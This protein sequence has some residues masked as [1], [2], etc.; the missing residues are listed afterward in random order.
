MSKTRVSKVRN[1]I[2]A[3]LGVELSYHKIADMC[4][5]LNIAFKPH[6]EMGIHY[7]SVIAESD[8]SRLINSFRHQLSGKSGPKSSA[9]APSKPAPRLSAA[10]QQT[11]ARPSKSPESH[12]RTTSPRPPQREPERSAAPQ[13]AAAGG[14]RPE[15][16]QR[17]DYQAR[18]GQRPQQEQRYTGGGQGRS[19]SQRPAGGGPS[20]RS[21]ASA[22]P[23]GS[24]P[25]S[26][27]GQRDFRPSSGPSDQRR[28]AGPSGGPGRSGGHHQRPAF[29]PGSPRKGKRSKYKQEQRKQHQQQQRENQVPLPPEERIIE[30]HHN[31]TVGELAAKMSV[32]AAEVIKALFMKGMMTTVNHVLELETA[33]MVAQE[34][35]YEVLMPSASDKKEAVTVKVA[36]APTLTNEDPKKLKPR[37]PVV[38]IMGHVDHGKTSLLDYIRN[39]KVTEG[40]AGGITQHIGAYMVDV[41]GKPIAF[42]DTPGHEAFTA[43]RARGAQVT[44]IAVLVIAADDGIK[45]QTIEAINHAKAAKVQLIVAVNKMDTPGADLERAKQQL[46]EHELIPEEWGGDTVIVPVSA[47]TGQGVDD[48]LEMILL[49]SEMLELKAN[50]DRRAVGVVIES[51]LDKGRGAVGTILIQNGTLKQGDAFVVGPVHGRV[52]AMVNERGKQIKKAGPS[53]PV[54]I[55]GFQDVPTSGDLFEVVKSDKEAKALAAQKREQ[56]DE[57][58]RSSNSSGRTNLSNLYENMQDGKVKELNLV[59]KADVQGS[60]DAIKHSLERL[61]GDK[62]QL[63]ILHGATGDISQYDIMLATASDALVVGFN[64]KADSNAER[65]AQQE[66]VEVRYYDIIYKLIEDIENAME[67]LLEPEMVEVAIGAAEVRAV[68]KISKLGTIAG[69][70]MVE[71]RCERSA[72]V[73][74]VRGG[75]VIHTG[76]ISSLKRF[77]DDVKEVST[78]YECGIGV[79]DY[80]TLQEGDRLEFFLIQARH[81]VAKAR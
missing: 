56:M 49:V 33:E 81:E 65:V 20:G 40:E 51:K 54:E 36:P 80:N 68:F 77:K 75:E 69:C 30:L 32:P 63:R 39:A 67:G 41:G 50:P 26:R 15:P 61:P 37:P 31:I 23:R 73:R 72:R 60:V 59:V 29:G 35:E 14:A 62:V 11:E 43:L 9:S 44:D 71:G 7:N 78:G 27:G 25:P 2:Q 18:A 8:A 48:L 70:Y 38:T 46:T 28:N 55:I 74:V 13:R 58:A 10:P 3:E 21:G 24:A 12:N 19:A 53:V 34:L 52:R 64:V 57:Q 22:A 76:R 1:E 17:N 79:K 66:Q 16:A 4:R 45:P 6:D 47:K 5:Q 42:L